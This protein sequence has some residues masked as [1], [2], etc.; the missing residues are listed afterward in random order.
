MDGLKQGPGRAKT[1]YTHLQRR[2]TH[3]SRITSRCCVWTMRSKADAKTIPEISVVE[4]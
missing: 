3:S 1:L 2:G 4:R